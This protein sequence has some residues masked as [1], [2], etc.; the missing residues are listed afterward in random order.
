[1]VTSPPAIPTTTKDRVL[2]IGATGFIGKFVAEASLTSEH[3]TCLLVRPGPLVP[4]K[5]AIV[6]TFQDKG[7]I[8]IHVSDHPYYIIYIF[9]LSVNISLVT[10]LEI[11]IC[12]KECGKFHFFS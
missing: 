8:V 12:L 11:I 9:F 2:I 4:S 7:A 3:P 10:L 1:M 6:K 5:D